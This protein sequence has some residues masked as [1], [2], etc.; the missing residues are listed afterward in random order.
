VDALLAAPRLAQLA[1][2]LIAWQHTPPEWRPLTNCQHW[3]MRS[4]DQPLTFGLRALLLLCSALVAIA[5]VSVRD[6]LVNNETM[7]N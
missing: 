2:E 3:V 1:L 7:P 6:N 4:E 5:N